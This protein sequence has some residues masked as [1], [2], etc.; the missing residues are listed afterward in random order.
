MKNAV[1]IIIGNEIL[2]GRTQDININYIAKKLT[3]SAI[4]LKEVRVIA[5]DQQTIIR[6][7][8]EMKDQ[9]DYVFTTGGIGPTHDDI[10]SYALSQALGLEY[11]INSEALQILEQYYGDELNEA[12]KKMACMP[13]G[14]ELIYN[15]VS[16]APGYI[17]KNIYV[18][19]GVPK[20]MQAMLDGIIHKIKGDTPIYSKTITTDIAEGNLA[21]RLAEIQKTYP[22]IEIGSYPFMSRNQLGTSI[23]CRGEDTKVIDIVM[24]D[25]KDMILLEDG[26]FFKE[27][28]I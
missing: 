19:A 1:L 15:P 21:K 20:I 17:I 10:T 25:I 16:Q 18:M 14:A 5:D 24:K 27:E 3:Q 6:H 13:E 26:R 2:S 8:R 23:V 12:R 28:E 11:A 9:Y 7:I 22:K 4:C